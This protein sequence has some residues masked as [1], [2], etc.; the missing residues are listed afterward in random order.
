MLRNFVVGAFPLAKQ[1]KVFFTVQFFLTPLIQRNSVFLP[2]QFGS[3]PF[4]EYPRAVREASSEMET[5][6]PSCSVCI[7]DG[8]QSGICQAS[9]HLTFSSLR[10]L[11]V[12]G[13]LFYCTLF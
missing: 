8:S 6:S 2:Y 4:S 3:N 11:T 10:F 5:G 7:I 9:L 13:F 12:P 1:L